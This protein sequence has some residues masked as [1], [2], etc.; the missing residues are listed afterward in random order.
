M[1]AVLKTVDRKVPGFESLPL[2]HDFTLAGTGDATVATRLRL[3]A[4]LLAAAFIAGACSAAATTR[5]PTTPPP[6]APVVGQPGTFRVTA[7]QM[8]V[9]RGWHSATLLP[10]G[11]VLIAGGSTTSS[12]TTA[13]AELYDP[14]TD[15]FTATGSMRT[16]RLGHSATLLANGKVLIAGGQIASAAGGMPS[17]LV[18][19]SDLKAVLKPGTPVAGL[20]R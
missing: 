18:P 17:A 8:S 7:G 14:M 11:K 16:A 6:A 1:A 4:A 3:T 2:R 19:W 9:D 5:P 13:S 15:S 20:V 10:N 12:G